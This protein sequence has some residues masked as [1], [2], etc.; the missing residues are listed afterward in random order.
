MMKMG[1]LWSEFEPVRTES[2]LD[3]GRGPDAVRIASSAKKK[4]PTASC[5]GHESDGHN[6]TPRAHDVDLLRE[7][8]DGAEIG[9][10]FQRFELLL[11]V[12]GVLVEQLKRVLRPA[13]QQKALVGPEVLVLCGNDTVTKLPQLSHATWRRSDGRLDGVTVASRRVDAIDASST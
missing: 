5:D 13:F 9:I 8:E 12:L 11:E 2:R 4:R 10:M 7:L 1:G 3:G 6:G